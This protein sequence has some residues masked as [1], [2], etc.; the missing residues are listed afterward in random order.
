MEVRDWLLWLSYESRLGKNRCYI[1]I[2]DRTTALDRDEGEYLFREID[3]EDF[4]DYLSY[5]VS[6]DGYEYLYMQ[7]IREVEI[8]W[9]APCIMINIYCDDD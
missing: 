7:K 2:E 3:P 9:E 1:F 8:T 4:E 5:F 6:K